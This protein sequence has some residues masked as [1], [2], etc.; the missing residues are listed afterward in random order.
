[1][2]GRRFATKFHSLHYALV[3]AGTT[4]SFTEQITRPKIVYQWGKAQQLSL[5]HV[6]TQIF[7][8]LIHENIELILWYYCYITF[9]S[10]R[11]SRRIRCTRP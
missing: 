8:V 11:A 7:F 6:H 4:S 2:R 10:L 3:E 1:M 5:H 9:G